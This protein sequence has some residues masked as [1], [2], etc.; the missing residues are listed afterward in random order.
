MPKSN[1]RQQARRRSAYAKYIA[2]AVWKAKRKAC[3]E[4]AGGICTYNA[5]AE[6]WVGSC[7][8]DMAN[9]CTNPATHAHHKTY[10]RFGGDELPED[11]QALCDFHHE[12]HHA[13]SPIPPRFR[14]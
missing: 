14:R 6:G 9:D 4:A 1:P 11:L 7:L 3:I 2:S 5:K 10:R 13:L 8:A 12:Y